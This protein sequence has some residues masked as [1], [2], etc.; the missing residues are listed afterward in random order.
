[1]KRELGFDPVGG[2]L[3][4]TRAALADMCA[5]HAGDEVS[6]STDLRSAG[7][8]EGE[9][10]HPRLIPVVETAATPLVRLVLDVSGQ[11]RSPIHCQGWVGEDHTL[12][13][14]AGS[15]RE[16]IFEATFLSRSLLTSQLA[17]FVGLGPRPRGKVADPVETDL[18]LLEA[19][20]G[21]SES[22]TPSQLEM[23]ID[24][25]DELV[26][27]WVEVLA[28]LSGDH[29]ARWR[30]GV[31]WNSAE[32]SPAARSLEIIDSD[33][34]LFLVTHVAPG[35]RRF[36]RVRVRPVTPTQLWRLLCALVPRPEEVA[37][38]LRP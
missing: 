34:G 27:A 7:L 14:V 8:L 10:V 33:V 28:L 1:M 30:V 13:L 18:G 16:Q 37:E 36:A 23:L 11:S 15:G 21:G 19:V 20:L 32:E 26:P 31:W 22:L 17:R 12:L 6:G 35:P 9:R 4:L 5:L 3:R 25:S 29:R 24:P 2:T 38:P